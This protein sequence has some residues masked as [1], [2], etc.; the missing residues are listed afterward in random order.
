MVKE[1]RRKLLVVS[2]NYAPEQTGIGK[3]VGEMTEWLASRDVAIRV[4][5]AP[6]YYPAWSV[7]PGYSGRRYAKE[8]L[9][10][11][12]VFRCPIYV[13]RYPRAI[14]RILH[15]LSFA[16]SSL[17]IVLW[18][19]LMWRPDV[20]FVVEPPLGAAPV[21]R[22]AA[23]LCG[24]RSWMHVQDFEVDAAFGLG[25][26]RA[27][28]LKRV[29]LGA[30]RWL[31]R[32]FDYVSTISDAMRAKLK[33][34][35]VA[36]E[37]IVSF[38]NWVDTGLIRPLTG[39]NALRVELGI[40]PDTRVVLYSGNMGEKQGLEIVLEVSQHF[41][42]D[43][44]VLFLMCGDGAV[45]PRIARAAAGLANVRLIPLQS[46]DRLNE[47]LNLADLHLLPQREAA[48]DLVL[49]SKLTAIMASGRP[50]IA[51]AR[52]GSDVARAAAHGG[53]VVPPGDIGA[54]SG[55]IRTLLADETLCD[56]LG[57]AGRAYAVEHWE[58]E[59]VLRRAFAML[60]VLLDGMSP[61][62]VRP[63]DA[64]QAEA[65]DS[66][67]LPVPVVATV[68]RNAGHQAAA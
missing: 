33:G 9:A 57:A 50:V 42:A 15:L 25:L 36:P 63:I 17:P 3:Y 34:K 38:P 48:E 20:V 1:Y 16:V 46:L 65:N 66:N 67:A 26:L 31:M 4:V 21:A 22:L 6:P 59:T 24:A 54:L 49:P 12:E 53:I 40:S 27:P 5:T 64:K 30:E 55:A 32:R 14:K 60:P 18:Q 45:R 7:S 44:D 68:L 51:T 13:P 28:L 47:L 58:R 29:I 39:L 23:A 56:S 2:L 52:S 35:G 43:P 62:T 8:T 11:V 41:C 10:G 37:R 61:A 19:A